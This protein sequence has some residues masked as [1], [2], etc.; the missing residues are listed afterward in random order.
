MQQW[1]CGAVGG[2]AEQERVV[3]QGLRGADWA[4]VE[5]EDPRTRGPS[6]CPRR[7]LGATRWEPGQ[8]N[9]ACCGEERR[10]CPVSWEPGWMG[11]SGP[12]E[13]GRGQPG[14]ILTGSPGKGGMHRRSRGPRQAPW[15][16]PGSWHLDDLSSPVW[17]AASES[18]PSG[19][20]SHL[21]PPIPAPGGRTPGKGRR[22]TR[23]ALTGVSQREGQPWLQPGPLVGLW[24]WRAP[25]RLGSRPPSTHPASV[26]QGWGGLAQFHGNGRPGSV[27]RGQGGLAPET[28][29]SC[30]LCFSPV[31]CFPVSVYINHN[32]SVEV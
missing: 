28:K 21:P 29:L 30:R 31:C 16:S 26:L 4:L 8:A 19:P 22:G 20:V 15:P 24:P 5:G 25:P 10:V 14:Q 3:A 18:L 27:L 6:L 32:S 7:L 12:R 13:L 2:Q 11:A 9:T 23:R 17:L 1:A